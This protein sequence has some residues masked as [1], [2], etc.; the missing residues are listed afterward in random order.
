[1]P[2]ILGTVR[3]QAAVIA[4]GLALA[5]MS[6]SVGFL[7]DD[8]AFRAALHT[9]APYDLFRFAP[10]DPTATSWLVR[11]GHLP[12]W[13]APELRI[14]FWRPLTSLAFALDD[15]VFG[16]HPLGYHLVSLAWLAVLFVAVAR[17][18][19]AFL[20][21]VAATLAL[22]VFTFAASH[23][24]AYAWISARHALLGA[25]FAA[26]A[27]AWQAEGRPA[28][29]VG[30]ALV[31][32]LLA[33]ESALAAVPLSVALAFG[34]DRRMR[35]AWPAVIVAV[36]YVAA[37]V[38]LG[39]G[40]RASG[41]YHDPASDPRGFA[42]LALTRLP[43][44][45][46]DAALAIPAELAF[47]V[48]PWKLASIGLVAVLLVLLA[49]RATR[50][51]GVVRWLA[52]GGI[53]ATF[54]GVTGYPSGRMLLVPDL[55]FAALLGLVLAGVREARRGGKVLVGVIAIAH[56]VLG[57]FAIVRQLRELTRRA[58]AT[59]TIADE[60][61]AL[62][63]PEARFFLVAA[64]DPSV[65]LYPRGLLA[66]EAPGAV[67]CWSVLSAAKA[68]HRL[69]RIDD[70]VL[71]LEPIERP[72]LD[73]S[74]DAL[75]RGPGHPFA[76]DDTVEQCG[77]TIRIRAVKDGLPSELE[78][79]FARRLDDPRLAFAVWQAG[80]LERLSMPAPGETIFLPW[81]PGPTRVF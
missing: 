2:S 19:R 70:H 61:R 43:I 63:P 56:L 14:H 54:L 34:R 62:A 48:T 75:F 9:R 68:G 51:R 11:S 10:G 7:T 5:S 76:V 49:V 17:F 81:A 4:L 78:I 18:F 57:P 69:T 42:V 36:A 66:Q 79:T 12:W 26:I 46:G 65:F 25:V 71:R 28:W 47:V 50:A 13:S 45:L 21:P 8:Q 73:G 16:D 27:L 1:M 23:V 74:F 77:A 67:R 64:S 33:S 37:Y 29:G 52:L 40:T 22:A 3:A 15:R 60:V 32:G 6:I 31:I 80:R 35:A 20:P 24:Q 58:R 55:A 59:E 72:L 44:L 53:A 38:A 39:F 30:L 41:G